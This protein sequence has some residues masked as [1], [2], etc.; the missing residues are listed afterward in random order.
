MAPQNS[1]VSPD[2]QSNH[3][4]KCH[5]KC[6]FPDSTVIEGRATTLGRKCLICSFRLPNP[7][8]SLISKKPSSSFH[9]AKTK[10]LNLPN[11]KKSHP[12]VQKPPTFQ[13]RK[14]QPPQNP[15]ADNN[16][17]S[18]YLLARH[19]WDKYQQSKEKREKSSSKSARAKLRYLQN[20]FKAL[21]V[22]LEDLRSSWP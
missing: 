11:I 18:L 12:Q 19:Y 20:L 8:E 13:A 6:L 9:K 17:K 21:V 2:E 15:K 22:T 7:R 1:P 16:E 5:S 14:P 4:P 3:C 10:P